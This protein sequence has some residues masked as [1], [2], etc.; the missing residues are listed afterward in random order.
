MPAPKLQLDHLVLKF[1][2]DNMTSVLPINNYFTRAG[3]KRWVELVIKFGWVRVSPLT[4]AT[5]LSLFCYCILFLSEAKR[6]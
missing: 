4:H 5:H 2:N 3:G 6:R 1:D